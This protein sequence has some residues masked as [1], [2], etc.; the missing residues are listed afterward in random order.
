MKPP[1]GIT[2]EASWIR[3]CC[4]LS[5]RA[6][7]LLEGR[8]ELFAA[9]ESI[10]RLAIAT[11]APSDDQDLQVFATIYKEL[12]HLP[13]GP[14]RANWSEEALRREQKTIS[15]LETQWRPKAL[16]AAHNLV[17]RY[18]W[19]YERRANLRRAGHAPKPN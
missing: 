4:R 15:A 13:V 9:A 17:E 7:D 12:S 5:A 2:N 1:E 16:E 8:L 14:E 19:A 10:Q 6:H 11:R 3:S 18:A